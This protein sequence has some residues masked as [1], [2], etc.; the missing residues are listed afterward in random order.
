M[1]CYTMQSA[2]II[3]FICIFLFFIF[4]N[5]SLI[6]LRIRGEIHGNRAFNLA[7]PKHEQSDAGGTVIL[8]YL[9][10]W[11]IDREEKN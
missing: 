10:G 8:L 9:F 1:H 6:F 5:I 4:F 7:G 2:L 11:N 3:T